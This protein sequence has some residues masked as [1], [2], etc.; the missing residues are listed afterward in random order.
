M[1]SIAA[2]ALA[3]AIIA[4]GPALADGQAGHAPPAAAT[5]S[6]PWSGC[7]IGAGF[8]AAFARTDLTSVNK[9]GA[10]F[11][12]ES[13]N[14][15]LGDGRVGCDAQRGSWVAGIGTGFAAGAL[16][17]SH[18]I[19]TFPTF[20]YRNSIP[21][22]VTA[23]ARAGYSI[24]DH[25]LLYVRAGGAWARDDSSVI[26]TTTV[27]GTSETATDDRFGWTVGAGT[28]YRL[29]GDL[30]GFLEYDYVDLGRRTVA[31]TPAPNTSGGE[32]DIL[33]TTRDVQ[34]IVLGLVYRFDGAAP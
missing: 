24:A 18:V 29:R 4:T 14:G 31:F 27:F 26:H 7:F 12:S 2:R 5:P 8:A 16:D 1:R 33:S 3:L 6:L 10:Q 23:T 19:P 17:G 22:I 20:T 11:G 13:D 15:M 34:T 21:L 25:A 9:P 30:S 32:A 28:E